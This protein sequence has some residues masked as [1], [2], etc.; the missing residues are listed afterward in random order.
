ML[1]ALAGELPVILGGGDCSE[2]AADVSD[3]EYEASALFC[4]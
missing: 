2:G 4:F 3:F 1:V